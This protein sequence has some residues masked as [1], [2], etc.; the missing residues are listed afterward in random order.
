MNIDWKIPLTED[1]A[2]ELQK[3]GEIIVPNQQLIDS[4]KEFEKSFNARL[5]EEGYFDLNQEQK[6]L[7]D[8]VIETCRKLLKK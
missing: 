5:Q 6:E 8:K 7:L 3:E 1:Q 2:L 4:I